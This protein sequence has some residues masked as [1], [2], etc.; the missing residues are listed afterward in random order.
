ME[1]SESKHN[2]KVTRNS[3]KDAKI[4]IQFLEKG[5]TGININLLTFRKSTY[6]TIGDACEH[7][8]GLFHVE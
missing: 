2:M 5:R 8:I 6:T 1:S 3:R 4:H 7:G